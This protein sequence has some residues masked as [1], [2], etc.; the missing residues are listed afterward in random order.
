V[1]QLNAGCSDLVYSAPVVYQLR[2]GMPWS[3]S[4]RVDKMKNEKSKGKNDTAK[5]K[6]IPSSSL[7]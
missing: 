3:C 7:S 2:E 6:N 5:F 4:G 1:Q